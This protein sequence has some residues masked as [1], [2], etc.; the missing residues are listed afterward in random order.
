MAAPRINSQ[1][2]L[3][4]FVSAKL[5]SSPRFERKFRL[6]SFDSD[7]SVTHLLSLGFHPVYE[8]R[9]INSI[10]FDTLDYRFAVENINGERYRVKPRLR[11]YGN[12]DID[13]KSKATL[14]YKFRDGFLGY[15]FSKIIEKPLY[16]EVDNI[17]KSDIFETVYQ[18]V[19]ISYQ[20]KYFIHPNGIRATADN[21]IVAYNMRLNKS[22][23]F[24]L[25]YD[26]IEFKYHESLD[27]HFREFVFPRYS[28]L[29]A[30]R[31][32]K[33]SKYVEGLLACQRLFG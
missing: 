2:I 24:M 17:I 15:K 7:I 11:W 26:V 14:E 5:L 29:A 23:D 10:Y 9:Q 18:S 27:N 22:T 28:K 19:K 8:E 12:V 31:L 32:N 20:R 4:E 33:S 3:N 13:N 30:Y 6:R 1:D 25:D 16:E 21:K